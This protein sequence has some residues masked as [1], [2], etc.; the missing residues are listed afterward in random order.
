MTKLKVH[1]EEGELRFPE[2]V[3]DECTVAK[4]CPL[5]ADRAKELLGWETE[6]D[7]IARMTAGMDE[8]KKAKAN[9]SYGGDY[10]LKDEEGNK[11]RCL[12]NLRNRFFT[13]SWARAICQDILNKYWRLNGETIIIGKE[14]NVLSA[15]HRLIALVLAA[16]LWKGRQSAHWQAIWEEEPYI[17]V[18]I[19]YGIDEGPETTRTLDNVKP[20]SLTDVLFTGEDLYGRKVTEEEKRVLC[21]MTEHCVRFLWHR[22]PSGTG[23]RRRDD[24]FAPKLTHSEAIAYIDNHPHIKKAVRKIYE[25]YKGKNWQVNN[26][27]MSAGTASA[28]L[29]LMGASASDINDYTAG[30]KGD[31]NERK[32]S[33]ENWEASEEYWTLLTK[34]D[35]KL[36]E[37][38]HALGRLAKDGATPNRLDKIDVLINGW[39]Y[40]SSGRRFKADDLKPDYVQDKEN[41]DQWVCVSRP[42]CDGIDLG[43]PSEKKD[44]PAREKDPT[45][46][47]IRK[48]AE[49]AR[50]GREKKQQEKEDKKKAGAKDRKLP[51][52]TRKEVEAEQTRKAREYDEMDR[53]MQEE[54]TEEQIVEDEQE[55]VEEGKKAEA[56]SEETTEVVV[57]EE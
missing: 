13:E 36:V 16:Q 41:L 32:L 52:L 6:D 48:G 14:G 45:P 55:L 1:E 57:Q 46:E 50:N 42:S 30:V 33:W 47:E 15:Q 44:P 26:Q 49:E 9:F 3:I 40:Y 22:T 20:R 34:G 53:K 18:F 12:R 38:H 4:G 35:A 5:R 11:V 2:P 29:Y 21:R 31:Q 7:F 39:K 28:L 17:E 56:E 37:V 25:E 10:L 54:E 8:K 43:E 19:V 23:G 51:P 24:A 27:R